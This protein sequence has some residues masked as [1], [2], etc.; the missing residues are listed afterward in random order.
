VLLGVLGRVYRAG[1]LRGLNS[2]IKRR[3][4]IVLN[5]PARAK[6]ENLLLHVVRKI[7]G[8]STYEFTLDDIEWLAVTL[9]EMDNRIKRH[10]DCC[11][12]IRETCAY[13]KKE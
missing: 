6:L 5:E 13:R 11:L 10:Q 3:F 12:P 9:I 2:L 4:Q 7:A 1:P 8:T